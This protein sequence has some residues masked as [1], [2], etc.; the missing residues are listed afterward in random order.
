MYVY[1]YY[2]YYYL[3]LS[4]MIME[5]DKSQDLWLVRWSPRRN[6]GVVPAWRVVGSRLGKSHCFSSSSLETGKKKMIP[7]LESTQTKEMPLTHGWVSLFVLFIPSANLMMSTQTRKGNQLSSVYWLVCNLIQKHPH[8]HTQNDLP[9]VWVPQSPVKLTYKSNN[10]NAQRLKTESSY[11]K[12][13]N[14][15]AHFHHF[16]ST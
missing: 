5:G 12:V 2:Y 13:R 3:E 11:T 8:N 4:K 1:Y 9:N 15:V 16:Y 14:K 7:P 10:P 6:E